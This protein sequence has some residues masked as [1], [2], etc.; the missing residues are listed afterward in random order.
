LFGAKRSKIGHIKQLWQPKLQTF[1]DMDFCFA[2]S[3]HQLKMHKISILSSNI[4][5]EK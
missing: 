4:L 3:K 5:L 1:F 2:S